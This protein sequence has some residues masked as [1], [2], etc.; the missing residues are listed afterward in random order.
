MARLL[1][2]AVSSE[3]GFLDDPW[4]VGV[5]VSVSRADDGTPV[6]GLTKENFRVASTEGWVDWAEY[7]NEMKW[8]PT[9]AEPSGCYGVGIYKKPPQGLT[10]GNR[11]VFGIQVRTFSQQKRGQG[12]EKGDLLSSSLTRV[13]RS[14]ESRSQSPGASRRVRRGQPVVRGAGPRA[15]FAATAS[16]IAWV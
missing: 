5:G 3:G 10:L 1:V 13:R 2:E 11:Y 16:W 7:V 15:S 6:T 4:A 14:S 12:R 9:D 8:E